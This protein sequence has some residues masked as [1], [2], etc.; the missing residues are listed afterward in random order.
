[1]SVLIKGGRVIDPASRTDQVMD[2]LVEGDRIVRM[3]PGIGQQANRVIDARGW[4]VVPGVIDMHTHLRQPGQEHKETIAT[5]TRAA[6]AGG[7]T[8]VA[9]MPNTQPPIDD[10]SV[11]EHVQAVARREGVVGVRVIGALTKGRQGK[12]LAEMGEMAQAGAVAFSDDGDTVADA[13]L[14]RSALQYAA[15]LGR[16]VI[17][18]A[19]DPSLARGGVMREGP[20]S[21]RLGLPGIPAEA[22]SIVVARD[23]ALAAATGAHLHVAHVST[24]RSVEL[25]RQ[26]KQAGVRVTAEVTPHHL[27]LTDEALEGYDA[28]AKVSPPLGTEEDRQALRQA[29]ADGIIDAVA[30]DHAP[31]APE[32]KEVE[33]DQAPFGAVGLETL[34]A[35]TLGA[36]THQGVLTPMQA[37]RALSLAPARILGLEGGVLAEGARADITL[38]D[39]AQEW[40]VEPARFRS[41]GRN[42]PFAGWKVQG[43]PVGTVVGGRIAMLAGTIDD[44]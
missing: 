40:T 32:E 30:S 37:V 38:F 35:L 9:C 4:W 39:P 44:G 33:L 41:R 42:T 7:V 2:V 15:D 3:A 36:L 20:V 5:G 16:P 6:A 43:R 10:A 12:E 26:A 21:L 17:V 27:F 22:E 29:L 24:A 14:M 31:H 25:I 28:S 1:M 11:V 18:H 34:V 19:L 23:I 8:A 13:S